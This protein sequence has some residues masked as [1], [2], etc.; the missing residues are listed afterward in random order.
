MVVYLSPTIWHSRKGKAIEMIKMIEVSGDGVEVG[1]TGRTQRIFKAVKTF[2]MLLWLIYGIIHLSKP[3]EC[4]TPRVNSEVNY[5][6]WVV[7]MCE[8]R[9][10]SCNRCTISVTGIDSFRRLSYVR[11]VGI[12]QISTFLSI[13]LWT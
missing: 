5:G 8:C 10:I 12:W 9:F 3:I 2:C 6:L 1:W 7:M 4:T 11:A 13:L